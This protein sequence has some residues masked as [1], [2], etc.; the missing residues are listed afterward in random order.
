MGGDRMLGDNLKNYRK[1][2]GLT[3]AEVA[4]ELN[5]ERSNIS[6]YEA[7]TY[8]PSIDVLKKMAKLFG[9][10]LEQLLD[11]EPPKPAERTAED[12]LVSVYQRLS[13]ESKTQL[14]SVAYLLLSDDLKRQGID[15][16]QQLHKNF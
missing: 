13:D 7:N 8:S 9:V 3:Q 2:A 4:A 14:M 10:S 5:L 15:I 1:A 6:R 12:K 11:N 16:E